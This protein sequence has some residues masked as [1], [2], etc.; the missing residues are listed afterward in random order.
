MKK[1]NDYV[2]VF[3]FTAVTESISVLVMGVDNIFDNFWALLKL[4]IEF[5]VLTAVIAVIAY[6][7]LK[8]TA[9]Q[10]TAK[11]IEELKKNE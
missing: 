1:L 8:K 4:S 11:V 3:V 10:F 6:A 9:P 2:K 7:I 5:G